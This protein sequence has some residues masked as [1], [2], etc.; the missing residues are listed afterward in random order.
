VELHVRR[1]Q[2]VGDVFDVMNDRTHLRGEVNE[3]V[4]L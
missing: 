4:A 1:D 3:A 2:P